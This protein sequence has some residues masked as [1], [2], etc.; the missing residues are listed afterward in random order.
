LRKYPKLAYEA[1]VN[2]L[3]DNDWDD[4]STDE[5]EYLESIHALLTEEDMAEGF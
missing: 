3:M 1:Y 4:L 2:G 5:Q